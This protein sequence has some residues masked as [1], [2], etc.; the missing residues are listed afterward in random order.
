MDIGFLI[1][2]KT[3]Q[4]GPGGVKVMKIA[5]ELAPYQDK[6]NIKNEEMCKETLEKIKK[7]MG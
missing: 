4:C 6:A 5:L 3:M 1:N 2:E 7:I